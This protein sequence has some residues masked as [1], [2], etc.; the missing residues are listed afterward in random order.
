MLF[1]MKPKIVAVVGPTASGK[2][3]LAIDLAIRFGGEIIS[4]DSMQVYKSMNIGTA[5]VSEE[6]KRGVVHHLIDVVSTCESFSCARY[7]DMAKQTV[8]TLCE[9]GVLPIFCGGTGQYLDAVL[10]DN[11]FSDAGVDEELRASLMERDTNELYDEL[12]AKD[13]VAADTIHPNNKKRVVRALETYYLTGVPKSEWD[14]RSRQRQSPYDSLI[15][16]LC[17]SD[18]SKL[19]ARIDSRVDDMMACGLLDEVRSLKL[20]P[21]TTAGAAIGYKELC[22]YLRGNQSLDEAVEQIKRA[23]RRYAKRQMTWFKSNE[24]IKWL[25]IDAYSA[26]ALHERAAELV[27]EFLSGDCKCNG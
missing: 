6:E 27:C 5:K 8:D 14:R 3:S 9:R 19:Y 22:E 12:K 16:G 7:A 13:P 17:A 24:H 21:D 18:R 11:V 15:I 23:S 26:D 2:S 1:E 10:T 4:C 20:S 25:D